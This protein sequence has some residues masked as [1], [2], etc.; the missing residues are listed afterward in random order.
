MATLINFIAE[1][2]LLEQGISLAIMKAEKVK[3]KLNQGQKLTEI[4]KKSQLDD[5]AEMQSN[6]PI[7]QQRM[8]QAQ[9]TDFLQSA[10]LVNLGQHQTQTSSGHQRFS[11]DGM[12]N[13]L[14]PTNKESIHLQVSG[15]YQLDQDHNVLQATPLDFSDKN[16]LSSQ[17]MQAK[18]MD[19]PFAQYKVKNDG[20]S[21][22]HQA[23]G[24]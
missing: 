24:S 9:V 18:L 11:S 19:P 3:Q 20:Q 21:Y 12:I 10:D 2:I 15:A 23:S 5:F 14:E 4:F 22:I 13:T 1:S 7:D 6:L 17:R 16:L 8:S